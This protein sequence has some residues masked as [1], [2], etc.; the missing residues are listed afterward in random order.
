MELCL[1]HVLH[2]VQHVAVDIV[3]Q[4]QRSQER[5]RGFRV[6]LS[7]GHGSGEFNMGNEDAAIHN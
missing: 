2:R 6:E 5:E 7:V 1:D 3:Q 4:V